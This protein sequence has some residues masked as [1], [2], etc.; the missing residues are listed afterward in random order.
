MA[1]MTASLSRSRRHNRTRFL[2]SD[3]LGKWGNLTACL[4]SNLYFEMCKEFFVFHKSQRRT[5]LKPQFL[6]SFFSMFPSLNL[7]FFS[8]QM[9]RRSPPRSPTCPPPSTSMC[10]TST[11]S[12]RATQARCPSTASTPSSPPPRRHTSLL[13]RRRCLRRRSRRRPPSPPPPPRRPPLPRPPTPRR[14]PT[15]RP[16]LRTPRLRR[17]YST[18][19]VCCPLL[20]LRFQ[21]AYSLAEGLLALSCKQ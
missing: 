11:S 15:R 21:S 17:L 2:T 10:Q 19:K 7:L 16:A 1:S 6:L 20:L 5:S 3:C 12:W 14:R 4:S 13:H 8:P 9:S 18:S